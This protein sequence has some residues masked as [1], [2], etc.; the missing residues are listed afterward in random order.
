M[1]AAHFR[2]VNVREAIRA[3]LAVLLA[4]NRSGDH[5]ARIAG[6][7]HAADI[8]FCVWRIADEREFHRRAY[9]LERLAYLQ[10]MVLRLHAAYIQKILPSLQRELFQ[11]FRASGFA[12]LRSVWDKS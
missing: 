12:H 11:S 6:I 8:L 9:L 2:S 5:D 4:I 10:R 3:K 7:A 1:R